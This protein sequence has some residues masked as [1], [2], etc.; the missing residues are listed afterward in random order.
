MICFAKGPYL[1]TV[2][3]LN[4]GEV[5]EFAL[6]SNDHNDWYDEPRPVPPIR[7]AGLRPLH[8]KST[9]QISHSLHCLRREGG[10]SIASALNVVIIDQMDWTGVSKLNDMSVTKHMPDHEPGP[11]GTA[12]PGYPRGV[13]P[14]LLSAFC[15]DQSPANERHPDCSV[16]GCICSCHGLRAS[17]AIWKFAPRGVM[18]QNHT[19]DSDPQ[20]ERA[21]ILRTLERLGTNRGTTRVSAR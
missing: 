16:P 5:H 11:I 15:V 6:V 10:A 7:V 12:C 4:Y 9:E 2:S 20:K 17:Q 21:G 19:E 3:T 8:H 1:V 14:P 18:V 13:W